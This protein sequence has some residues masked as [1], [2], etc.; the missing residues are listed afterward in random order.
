MKISIFDGSGMGQ[1]N[2]PHTSTES[3]VHFEKCE[4]QAT[5]GRNTQSKSTPLCHPADSTRQKIDFNLCDIG[6]QAAKK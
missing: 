6:V 4:K 3:G 5:I 1:H 2:V